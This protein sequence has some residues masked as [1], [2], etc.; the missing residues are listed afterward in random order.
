LL[1]CGLPLIKAGNQVIY[2]HPL[3]VI[4]TLALS[5][6]KEKNLLMVALSRAMK[7]EQASGS[8]LFFLN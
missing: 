5:N 3:I 8:S 2:L 6:R 4:K 7:S 1:V